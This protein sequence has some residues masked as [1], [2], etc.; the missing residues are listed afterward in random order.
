[1]VALPLAIALSRAARISHGDHL[2]LVAP[3]LQHP[4][5]R[6]L[7][8]AKSPPGSGWCPTSSLPLLMRRKSSSDC[9]PSP[10]R[11]TSTTQSPHSLRRGCSSTSRASAKFATVMPPSHTGFGSTMINKLVVQSLNAELLVPQKRTRAC[12]GFDPYS[13][14]TRAAVC[15]AASSRAALRHSRTGPGGQVK[16]GSPRRRTR[17][18]GM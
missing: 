1:M 8:N 2:F 6:L 11:G 12:V 13:P 10:R 18:A 9:G 17:G 7:F 15:D 14:S 4:T 16:V 3:R 5:V